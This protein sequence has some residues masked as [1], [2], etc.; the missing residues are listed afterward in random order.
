MYL[1]LFFFSSRRR[2]TRSYGDWSSDVCS[3]DLLR[4]GVASLDHEVRDHPVE[5]GSVVEA[6]V[7]E[8][9]EVG[10]GVRHLVGEQLQLDG[11]L[12]GLDDRLL[13]GHQVS[14][15]RFSSTCATVFIP[16]ITTDT[17]SLSSTNLRA[18]CAPLRPAW[19]A[20]SCTRCP[21]ATTWATYG[22]GI[23]ARMSP[24]SHTLSGP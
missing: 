9:L 2:H 20:S 22:R 14:T 7:R 19:L 11:A 12:H 6:R 15:E 18:S 17:A 23:R 5:L 13:V 8:L 4:V 1:V 3:S 16:T 21:S 24:F 10:H